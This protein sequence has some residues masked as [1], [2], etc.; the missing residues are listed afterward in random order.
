WTCSRGYPRAA[1]A[2]YAVAWSFWSEP[3]RAEHRSE[4][5]GGDRYD[6]AGN[7]ARGA[8]CGDNRPE[9]R[10][11]SQ[12]SCVSN[13]AYEH[14][15]ERPGSGALGQDVAG[16]RSGTRGVARSGVHTLPS[17]PKQASGLHG[18]VRLVVR[19][20]RGLPAR[21]RPACAATRRAVPIATRTG[22]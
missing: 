18:R 13:E 20:R 2:N 1:L 9:R 12:N 21:A 10:A 19:A 22:C 11:Y 7:P 17:T 5:D 3:P 16:V 14:R 15:L 4:R 6:E 8:R